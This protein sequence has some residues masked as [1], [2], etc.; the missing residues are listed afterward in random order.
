MPIIFFYYYS[1]SYII[2]GGIPLTLSHTLSAPHQYESHRRALISYQKPVQ[3]SKKNQQH[4]RRVLLVFWGMM[5]GL[6]SALSKSLRQQ[7]VLL[8]VNVYS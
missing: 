4:R 5:K 2:F 1:I 8:A 7:K 3:Q 6:V